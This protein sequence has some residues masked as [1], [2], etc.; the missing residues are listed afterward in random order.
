[1]DGSF[2]CKEDP[3]HFA[4]GTTF[5][6]FLCLSVIQSLPAVYQILVQVKMLCKTKPVDSEYQEFKSIFEVETT[7]QGTTIT[8]P[9]EKS[10]K[11]MNMARSFTDVR[12]SKKN[13]RSNS[14]NGGKS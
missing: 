12:I 5:L 7:E 6:V 9:Q 3:R 2:L 1:M 13:A 10:D 8:V 11:D 14:K 4:F